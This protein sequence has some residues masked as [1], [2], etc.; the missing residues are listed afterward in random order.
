MR[1]GLRILLLFAPFTFESSESLYSM[2]FTVKGRF[3]EENRG[4]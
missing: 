3:Y 4:L 1:L 2:P